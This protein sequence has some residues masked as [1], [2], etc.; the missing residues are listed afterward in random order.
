MAWTEQATVNLIIDLVPRG[1][2]DRLPSPAFCDLLGI[3]LP[4]FRLAPFDAS[5]TAKVRLAV[6]AATRDPKEW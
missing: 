1:Q 6:R 3:S 5:A 2:I 4:C